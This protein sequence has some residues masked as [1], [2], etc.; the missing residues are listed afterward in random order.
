M[1]SYKSTTVTGEDADLSVLLS[2]LGVKDCKDLCFRTD[3][4]KEK[5]PDVHNIQVLKQL[6]RNG[7]CYDL[8]FTHA[9]KGCDTTS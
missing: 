5:I 2:H 8:L 4:H 1:S 7:V 6:L 3:K 9:F